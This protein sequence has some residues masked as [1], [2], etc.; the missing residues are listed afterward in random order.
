MSL[1]GSNAG[2]MWDVHDG[3]VHGQ[4]VGQVRHAVDRLHGKEDGGRYVV[5]GPDHA[6]AVPPD[7]NAD[8]HEDAPGV[9]DRREGVKEELV[10]LGV[11]PVLLDEPSVGGDG[12]GNE[13]EAKARPWDA[14]N[15]LGD[16]LVLVRKLFCT[17]CRRGWGS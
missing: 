5:H 1:N 2:G 11:D 13:E 9:G 6:S 12:A 8:G 15:R 7:G 10:Q 17:C 4:L 3:E 16:A 14:L